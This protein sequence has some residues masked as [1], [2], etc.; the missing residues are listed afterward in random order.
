MQQSDG[1]LCRRG[2]FILPL[3]CL[4]LFPFLTSFAVT[5]KKKKAPPEPYP[6]LT[7]I[8]KKQEFARAEIL[9]DSL[10]RTGDTATRLRE[11][12]AYTLLSQH[13]TLPRAEQ[14]LQDCPQKP[15]RL[16]LL[17]EILALQYKFREAAQ[18]YEAYIPIAD[19]R[20]FSDI[21]ARQRAIE[22]K[23]ALQLIQTTYRPILYHQAATSWDSITHHPLLAHLPYRL[24]PLP[25][26]LYG[27]FDDAQ[28]KPPTYIAY[29]DA[30]NVGSKVIFANRRS[31][32]GQR[33]LYQVEMHSDGL[34]S[35]PELLVP[36]INTS[37]DEA[38]GILTADGKTLYFTSRGHYG[39]GGFDIFRTTYDPVTHTWQAPVNLG[40]PYNTPYD[41]YLLG[42]PDARGRIVIASNR[43]T[44]PDS[45][46]LFTLS[47]DPE[48]L[49]EKLTDSTHL[50]A[51]ALF[52]VTD[53]VI[54]PPLSA[55]V[56][57]HRR[58]VRETV[59]N[60]QYRDV[61]ADPEYQSLLQKGY[62]QQRIADS[63]RIDLE[64]Y[65]DRLW[66]VKTSTERKTLESKITDFEDR[67]LAAQRKADSHFVKASRIEQEYIVGQRTTVNKNTEGAY[68]KDVPSDLHLAK[69]AASVM[70]ANELRILAEI[71][72]QAP[73]FWSE[74]QELWKQYRKIYQMLND[75]VSS[76][77]SI[78]KAEHEA[79][80]QSQI[81][82]KKYTQNIQTRRRIFSECL[83]VA[84][85]KGN[86]D[87]KP[88]IFAMEAKAKECYAFAQT[89]LNN[90]DEQDEGRSA[91][92]ALL[93]EEIGNLYYEVSFTY[94]WNMDAYR[95]RVLKRIE[96][97]EPYLLGEANS[98]PMPPMPSES[99]Q[100]S[101]RGAQDSITTPVASSTP[102]TAVPIE[103]LIDLEGLQ[104]QN[105][106]PY[107]T[108]DDVPRDITAPSGVIYRLQLGAYSNPIDPALFQGMVPIVAE[109]LQGGKIRKYYAGAFRHKADAEKGKVITTQCGFPDA[110]VVAWYNGRKVTLARALSV[111]NDPTSA[112]QPLEPNATF[113]VIVGTYAGEL[114]SYVAETLHLLAP[115]KE[116]SQEPL[117][118][119]RIRYTIGDF[120]DRGQAERLR[121][122]LLGSGLLEAAL[123]N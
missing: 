57:Q 52:Q 103:T 35:H 72:R 33:D 83:A 112:A 75:T 23:N 14:L 81:F 24:L 31:R 28:L 45:I 120:T 16:Y 89:L 47:Y 29:P 73:T 82:V 76:T 122:N 15:Y 84:Y 114:P 49:C 95:K 109:T 100:S 2:Y 71:A 115:E 9:A 117:N 68:S 60:T 59:R 18:A 74:T 54:S 55:P 27:G 116:I 41:D 110:F 105:P 119:G 101:I 70:Q 48:Q 46:Q 36:T 98:K 94:A 66:Y 25:A 10:I 13:K 53:A 86:R 123:D 118:D 32:K 77:V 4:L 88:S 58:N 113:R 22:C 107:P 38:L 44:H 20:V 6:T 80:L 19:K 106:S 111:E 50:E 93:T 37:F 97:Y 87:A 17:G 92:F 11:I 69:P 7:E 21:E 3:L 64:K 62:E 79:A 102:T 12:L 42:I 56:T 1:T 43:A 90:I 78:I 121:D 39:M 65:R 63:L 8:L 34:W 96:T 26:A 91:F 104:I 85:M 30:M 99:Q 40:F 108:E 61:D 5:A 51:R 67:M